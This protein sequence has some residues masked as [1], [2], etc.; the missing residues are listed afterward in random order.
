MERMFGL[1]GAA[2][3]G[4]GAGARGSDVPA[5]GKNRRAHDVDALRTRM[6]QAHDFLRGIQA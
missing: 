4:R 5:A 1:D 2:D 6:G 3:E